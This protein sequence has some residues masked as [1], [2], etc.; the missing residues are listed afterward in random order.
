LTF[1]DLSSNALMGPLPAI[2]KRHL[3]KMKYGTYGFYW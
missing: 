3:T 2:K 1:L